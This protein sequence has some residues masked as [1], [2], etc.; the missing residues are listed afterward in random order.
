MTNDV[1]VEIRRFS[2]EFSERLHDIA[3]VEI[4]FDCVI[5]ILKQIVVDIREIWTDS[6]VGKVTEDIV[7]Y[8]VALTVDAKLLVA[9]SGG[10]QEEGPALGRPVLVMRD[11]T[12]RPE[13]LSTGTVKLVG[14]D[15]KF[16]REQVTRSQSFP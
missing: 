10:I 3:V 9:D 1:V 7:V 5:H 4:F 2:S 16:M 8:V 13:A 15:P 11:V 6:T 12:E 14:T